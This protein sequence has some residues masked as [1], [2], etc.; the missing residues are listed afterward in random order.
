MHGTIHQVKQYNFTLCLKSKYLI[1]AYFKSSGML[2][3]LHLS[4][5]NRFSIRESELYG[6]K[7]TGGGETDWRGRRIADMK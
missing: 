4:I 6:M 7:I 2:A 5:K 1:Y 3:W